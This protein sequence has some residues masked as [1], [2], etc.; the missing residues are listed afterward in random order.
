M[1]EPTLRHDGNLRFAGTVH[2]G[3]PADA[4]GEAERVRAL[5]AGQEGVAAYGPPTILFTLPPHD[6]PASWEC[7]V[8][9]TLTGLARPPAGVQIEDYARLDALV[10]PHTGPIRELDATYRRLVERARVLGHP[11]RPY[12]RL[13]LWRKRL[14]DGNAL[15]LAEVSVFVDRW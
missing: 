7:S 10:L 12:W 3:Y 4:E 8:G 2:P 13:Q 5:F 14:A 15:P 9:V 11:L 6:A 1:A